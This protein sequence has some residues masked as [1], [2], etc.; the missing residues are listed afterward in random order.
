MRYLVIVMML[1]LMS[2][3]P[4]TAWAAEGGHDHGHG[5]SHGDEAAQ[6][7]EQSSAATSEQ[8]LTGE[9][10]D[11]TCY[12]SEGENGIGKGHASC[13]RKCIKNG[14]PVAI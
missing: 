13:A 2:M 11:V 5:H 6:E 7:D 9:V 3:S 10:V 1:A 4:V 12:L 14:L 8:S